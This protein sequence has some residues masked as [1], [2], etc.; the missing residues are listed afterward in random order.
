MRSNWRIIKPEGMGFMII[1]DKDFE[2][3]WILESELKYYGLKS[4]EQELEDFGKE[5]I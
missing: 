3:T 5:D 1:N 2:I 4:P